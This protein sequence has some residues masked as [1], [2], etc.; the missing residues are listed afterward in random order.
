M[1]DKNKKKY[2]RMRFYR[3]KFRENEHL[4]NHP[5]LSESRLLP[6]YLAKYQK[7]TNEKKREVYKDKPLTTVAGVAACLI[8]MFGLF[9]TMSYS[10]SSPHWIDGGQVMEKVVDPFYIALTSH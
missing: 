7:A 10:V 4:F 2:K 8:L 3:E 6:E 9:W 1:I 5:P